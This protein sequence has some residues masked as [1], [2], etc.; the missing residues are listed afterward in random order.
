M[1]RFLLIGVFA[2]VGGCGANHNSIFRTFS[3]DAENAG[4]LRLSAFVIDAKQRAVIAK[5]RKGQGYIYC[6]E[7]SPDA[8]SVLSSSL[9]AKGRFSQSAADTD[10]VSELAR[11]MSESG[12]TISRTQTIQILRESL[13]RTCERYANYEITEEELTIQAIRDQ[14]M[15]VSVL[16]IEQLTGSL[17]PPPVAISTT[18][19][20]DTGSSALT[21]QENVEKAQAKLKTKTAAAKAAEDAHKPF[22]DKVIQ[23]EKVQKEKSEELGD[24]KKAL[25]EARN[26]SPKPDKDPIPDLEAK[27]LKVEVEETD[28][29][30]LVATRE[31]EAAKTKLAKAEAETEVETQIELIASL[32]EK[33]SAAMAVSSSGASKIEFGN[34][35]TCRPKPA[36]DAA[37]ASISN[38]VKDIVEK[39]FDLDEVQLSCLK[40]LRGSVTETAIKYSGKNNLT[41]EALEKD[42]KEKV[43]KNFCFT[44]MNRQA[45]MAAADAAAKNKE[46]AKVEK[47]TIELKLETEQLEKSL[48]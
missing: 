44:Y 9:S 11:T 36:S 7:P 13:Y 45:A 10:A 46:A 38:A 27:I 41:G 42:E 16:A 4:D 17:V 43:Y 32:K 21:A 47:E 8:F 25:S 19:E 29:K 28:A 37:V 35:E 12:S 34:C 48:D 6:V 33:L 40:F 2:L 15:I 22:V 18:A 30:A 1:L 39:T 14:R 23:A 31:Q 24:L 26:A 5:T 20:A 3:S